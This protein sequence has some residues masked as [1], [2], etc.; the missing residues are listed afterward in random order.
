MYQAVFVLVAILLLCLCRA[1]SEI[2][3]CPYR[4]DPFYTAI[5]R[6]NVQSVLLPLE[7]VVFRLCFGLRQGPAYWY[8][9]TGPVLVYEKQFQRVYAVQE[10]GVRA[11]RPGLFTWCSSA[12]KRLE[13][14]C[15]AETGRVLF[16]SMS[17]VMK[18][19]VFVENGSRGAVQ[20]EQRRW[21]SCWG[22]NRQKLCDSKKKCLAIYTQ[23]LWGLQK[24]ILHASQ[25][26]P[27]ICR[28]HLRDS[29]LTTSFP[30]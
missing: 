7:P 12:V 19:H 13:T 17:V 15:E 9:S 30:S 5:S 16:A 26:K 2:D 28:M 11:V 21:P 4:C 6:L 27:W 29:P 3:I 23:S 14:A 18:G 1:N 24:C 22:S 20:W 10:V 8:V 25:K